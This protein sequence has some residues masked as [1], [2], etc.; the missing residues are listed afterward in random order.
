MIYQAVM[1][2]HKNKRPKNGHD[3]SPALLCIRLSSESSQKSLLQ[4]D[5]ARISHIT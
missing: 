1:G 3:V 2:V 5:R 4:V